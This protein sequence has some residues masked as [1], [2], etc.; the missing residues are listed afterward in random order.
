MDSNDKFV[1]MQEVNNVFTNTVM[2]I[3]YN[4]KKN[5]KGNYSCEVT[6]PATEYGT[7]PTSPHIVDE[8]RIEITKPIN[9]KEMKRIYVGLKYKEYKVHFDINGQDKKELDL[10]DITSEYLNGL[11][12][13]I[14][15]RL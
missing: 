14:I 11:M 4:I 8:A 12:D 6:V 5:S 2:P 13:E 7:L 15:N 10:N 9:R 1:E 3:F